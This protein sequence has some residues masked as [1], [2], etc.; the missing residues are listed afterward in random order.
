MI[1]CGVIAC[2]AS[3]IA[4]ADRSSVIQPFPSIH[5]QVTHPIFPAAT[6]QPRRSLARIGEDQRV[7][8]EARHVGGK[9]D[10]AGLR[11]WRRG[12]IYMALFNQ[13]DDYR[14]HCRSGS[15]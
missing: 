13:R 7:D 9:D 15:E 4:T 6:S 11:S 14:Q 12:R 2:G 3:S 10:P 5:C 8:A 1:A